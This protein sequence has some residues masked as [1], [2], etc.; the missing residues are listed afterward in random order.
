[1]LG[2][3]VQLE[4]SMGKQKVDPSCQ[5][6]PSRGKRWAWYKIRQH[7]FDHT[8][9]VLCIAVWMESGSAAADDGQKGSNAAR[10]RSALNKPPR[11]K[12]YSVLN[13]CDRVLPT[14]I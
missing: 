7:V 5:M 1:M 13:E 11:H 9:V 3:W 4:M 10:R 2:T 8:N 12:Q 6:S 14:G